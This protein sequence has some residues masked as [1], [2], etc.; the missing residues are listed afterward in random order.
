MTLEMLAGVV[1]GM[2]TYVALG[3]IG[4]AYG[5]LVSLLPWAWSRWVFGWGLGVPLAALGTTLHYYLVMDGRGGPS[6]IWVPF[7][8]GAIWY[9]WIRWRREG[10]ARRPSPARREM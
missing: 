8:I 9:S 5:W 4:V 1:L 3:L 6:A 10:R 7:A 2:G